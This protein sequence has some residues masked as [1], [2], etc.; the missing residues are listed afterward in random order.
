MPGRTIGCP[1]Q[2]RSNPATTALNLLASSFVPRRLRDTLAAQ[3]RRHDRG[4][5]PQCGR[6]DS[7]THV[8]GI[9][10]VSAREGDVASPYDKQ[11]CI[12]SL[13]GRNQDRSSVI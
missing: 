10:L 6:L 9:E 8:F 13:T 2:L 11:N 3:L 5:R 12:T 4:R 1:M 7:G